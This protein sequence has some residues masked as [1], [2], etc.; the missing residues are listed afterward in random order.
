MSNKAQNYHYSPRP[1]DHKHNIRSYF[2]SYN[3]VLTNQ[4]LFVCICL[5]V[6]EYFF[7]SKKGRKINAFLQFT[8]NLLPHWIRGNDFNNFMFPSS[9]YTRVKMLHTKLNQDIPGSYRREAE[10]KPILTNVEGLKQIQII[11]WVISP[12]YCCIFM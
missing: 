6:G 8:K 2:S 5:V 7:L 12:A 9:C 10:K 11:T 3:H 4:V 1:W